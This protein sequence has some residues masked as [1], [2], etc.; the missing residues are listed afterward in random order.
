MERLTES[1]DRAE[2]Q[3]SL[4]YWRPRVAASF[5]QEQSD[6]FARLQSL[7]LRHQDNASLRQIWQA[8]TDETL[9][10]LGLTA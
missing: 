9:A 10:A 5:G 7:G 6:K 2:L 1:A 4:D 3:A 8:R